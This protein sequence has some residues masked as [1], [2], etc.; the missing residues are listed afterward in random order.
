MRSCNTAEF[1][2]LALIFQWSIQQQIPIQAAQV[3]GP[4]KNARPE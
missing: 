2:N 1:K 3:S 4:V